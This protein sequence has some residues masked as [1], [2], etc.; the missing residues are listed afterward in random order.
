MTHHTI[1]GGGGVELH[2]IETGNPHGRPILFIHAYSQ[3]SLMWSRQLH[4]ELADDYRLVAMDFRGHGRSG[5]PHDAYSDTRLW[6]DDVDAV[7]LGLALQQPVLCGWSYG[8]LVMLDYVRHYGAAGIA[9]FISVGG[10]TRLGSAD[11]ASVITP[12]FL[13]LVPAFFSTD[14]EESVRGLGS[15]LRLCY[16]VEPS[17][18]DQ[19]LILGYNVSVPPYVR[20]ALFSRVLDNDDVLPQLRNTPVLIVQ[21]EH[22]AILKP[23][24]VD[25]HRRDFPQ[26]EVVVI[27]AA[28]HGAF[29]DAPAA[30]NGHVRRF[31]EHL[32]GAAVA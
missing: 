26:A 29:R 31:C 5:K 19:Y 2:V 30:F 32:A 1:T 21:G 16:L 12:A 14:A 11:A 15:L 18:E 6:A 10:I 24:L 9:G 22:D 7:I 4:S 17:I 8:P 27:P 25:R 13:N 3:C 28:G 20:Q 23:E